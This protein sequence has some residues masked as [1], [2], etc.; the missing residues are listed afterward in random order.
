MGT[1]LNMAL[2]AEMKPFKKLSMELE[3][4][5]KLFQRRMDEL[6]AEKDNLLARMNA[7]MESKEVQIK[8]RDNQIDSITKDCKNFENTKAILEI[9]LKELNED[10]KN[11]EKTI[12]EYKSIK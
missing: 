10:L 3:D 1:P 4:S 11:H 8:E 2:Q 6:Q 9:K 5:N 7:E 12:A